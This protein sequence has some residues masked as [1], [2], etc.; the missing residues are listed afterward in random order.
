MH[1]FEHPGR[2]N[3]FLIS[4]KDP[5]ALLYNDVSVLENHH[6]SA[7]WR[8]LKSDAEYNFLINLDAAEWKHFRN[9]VIEN[10]LATDLSKHFGLIGNF[11][12]RVNTNVASLPGKSSIDWKNEQDRLIVGQMI[13]K[14]SDINAP[15]KEKDLHVQWTERICEEFYQQVSYHYNSSKYIFTSNKN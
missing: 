1:D 9:L 11:K 5:L 12:N 2:N 3:Q 13:I 15:L 10:I 8:L 4:T 14:L 7:S 6:A